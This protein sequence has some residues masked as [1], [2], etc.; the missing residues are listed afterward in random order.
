MEEQVLVTDGISY[1]GSILCEHLLDAAHKFTVA[2][3]LMYGHRV[4]LGT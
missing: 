2:D 1:L 4:L 3:N